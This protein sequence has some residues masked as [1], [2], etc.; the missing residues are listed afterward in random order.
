[1]AD[2]VTAADAVTQA[3]SVTLADPTMADA[4][5]A[6]AVTPTDQFEPQPVPENTTTQCCF[7]LSPLGDG[8]PLK[9]LQ[10]MHTFHKCCIDPWIAGSGLPEARCCPY[11]CPEVTPAAVG[12]LMSFDVDLTGGGGGDP[13]PGAPNATGSSSSSSGAVAP[14]D[15]Q[16]GTPEARAEREMQEALDLD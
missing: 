4:T 12:A 3:H 16:H 10:C 2:A 7:C 8:T 1:M 11:K 15:A 13:E 14:S 9:T 5:P 6:D